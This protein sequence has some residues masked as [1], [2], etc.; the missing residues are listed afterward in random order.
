MSLAAA[1]SRKL[2]WVRDRLAAVGEP[3]VDAARWLA[4]V[5]GLGAAVTAHAFR[6]TSWRRPVR[7]SFRHAVYDAGVRALPSVLVAAVLVGLGMVF[8]ALYWL[9]TFGQ[10]S[11]VGPLLTTVLVREVAP[12]VVGLLVLGRSGTATLIALGTLSR[13]GQ[14]AALDAQGIDPLSLLVMPRVLASAVAGV[15]L[16]ILFVATALIAG[17]GAALAISPAELSLFD[18][19]DNVLRAMGPSNFILLPLK[20]LMIGL[21]VSLVACAIVFG[22][23]ALALRPTQLV[24]QGFALMVLAALAVSGIISMVL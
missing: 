13:G 23:P 3:T 2:A 11:L 7:D 5:A 22:A 14:I 20:G 9:G 12:I 8:Q 10:E 19:L 17:W 4:F 1:G 16:T 18:F 15:T 6:A 21:V 24:P